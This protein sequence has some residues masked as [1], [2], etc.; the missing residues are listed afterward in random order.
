M[1]LGTMT[2]ES[3]RVPGFFESDTQSG[4]TQVPLS[5]YERVLVEELLRS[6]DWEYFPA[7]RWEVPANRRL[8]SRL[9]AAGLV[10]VHLIHRT[11]FGEKYFSARLTELGRQWISHSTRIV[12]A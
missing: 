12:P 6:T 10:T 9:V 3:I 1:G 7:Y 5:H 4:R 11:R 2:T 8:A